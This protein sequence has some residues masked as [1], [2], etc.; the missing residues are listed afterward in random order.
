MPVAITTEGR[1]ACREENRLVPGLGRDVLETCSRVKRFVSQD[2]PR[3]RSKG[4]SSSRWRRVFSASSLT[5]CEEHRHRRY[6]SMTVFTED[7]HRHG[8]Q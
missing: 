3:T 1:V 2:G 4:Y 6:L 7:R 5:V 8:L